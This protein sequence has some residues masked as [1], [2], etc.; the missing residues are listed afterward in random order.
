MTEE[1]QVAGSSP[2]LDGLYGEQG[3]IY[4]GVDLGTIRRHEVH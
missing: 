3:A 2:R 4:A 1:S